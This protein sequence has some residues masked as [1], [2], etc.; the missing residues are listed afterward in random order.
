MNG[1]VNFGFEENIFLKHSTHT[2]A[3]TQEQ[4]PRGHRGCEPYFPLSA[5]VTS[6]VQNFNSSKI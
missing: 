5:S 2:T 3:W 1:L 6:V 4:L